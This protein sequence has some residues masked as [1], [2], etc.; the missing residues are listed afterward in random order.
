MTIAIDNIRFMLFALLG[1]VSL[2]A[3][4]AHKP[5]N[6]AAEAGVTVVPCRRTMTRTRPRAARRGRA[7]KRILIEQGGAA[8][9]SLLLAFVFL[10][11]W[12]A[13]LRV[14]FDYDGDALYFEMVVKAV[15]DHGWFLTNPS[16]G[17]PG[18]LAMHDF[19]SADSLHLLVI[20]VMSWGTSDWALLYNLYFILSFPLI[21]V[22]ALAVLRQFRVA[23]A[24]ALVVSLLFSFLPSRLSLAEVHYFLSIFYEVPLAILVALWVAGD[25]PPLGWR[26]GR[27]LAA[28]AICV[29]IAGT[30]IYYAFFAGALIA[31]GGIWGALRRR[32]P[33]NALA[34]L[35]FTGVIMTGLA[36][37]AAPV[38]VHHARHG[39]NPEVAT[40]DPRDAEI[41]G[42]RIAQLLLPV[43]KHPVPALRELKDRYDTMAPFPGETSASSLG[44]VGGVGFL[45]LL[46]VMLLPMGEGRPRR[47]LWR[48]LGVLNLLALLI[49]TT[50]GFGSLFAFVVT[51]DIR[52]YAR[53]HVF[54]AF[55]A[56]FAVA[57][58][59]E[60]LVTRRARLGVA[61]CGLV[62]V[63]GLLDQV[64]SL[65]VRPYAKVKAHYRSDAALV[66]AIEAAVPAGGMILE[67]PHQSFPEGGPSAGG[68]PLNYWPLRPYLHARSLRW[69]YPAMRGRSADAWAHGIATLPAADLVRA[70]S[71]VGFDG[72]LVHRA[73]YPDEGAK[74]E[75]ELAA[76][77]PSA[78][79]ATGSVALVLQPGRAQPRGARRRAGR[80]ARVAARAGRSH[81]RPAMDQRLLPGR[82]RTP[83]SVSLEL[84]HRHHRDRERRQ[85]RSPAEDHDGGEGRNAADD[86]RP[87]W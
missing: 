23:Y 29:L 67:V 66:R 34:A 72:I 10:R 56:L 68:K 54:V 3:R 27:T 37:Q 62:L 30:G 55:L 74:I 35:L 47:E 75:G 85:L 80:S 8:A 7:R 61:A 76:A 44:V 28:V 53:M 87:R 49:A 24:P 16:L 32:T 82:E 42:M 9:A 15:V 63:V 11:L 52:T 38:A 26:R 86:V 1:R 20:K 36:V 71:D 60:R 39:P 2:A 14:P 50:G 46:G 48:A 18:V 73:G 33:R 64:T 17:A 25:D 79:R 81:P 41:F 70:A 78:T 83:P 77:L 43:A 5:E 6:A 40:R 22:S 12:Q 13:D 45:A 65:A 4:L 59:L 21:T 69:S 57:L 31:L 19:P 58:L 84:R 51:P